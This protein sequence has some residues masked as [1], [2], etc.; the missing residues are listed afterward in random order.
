[1]KEITNDPHHGVVYVDGS[2]INNPSMVW[3]SGYHGYV[4]SDATIGKKSGDRPNKFIITSKG[5][6]DSA[7]AIK[8]VHDTVI[9]EYYINGYYSSG[10]VQGSNNTGEIQAIINMVKFGVERKLT[11]MSILSDSTYALGWLDKINHKNYSFEQENRANSTYITELKE[12]VITATNIGLTIKGYKVEAHSADMGNYIADQLALLGRLISGRIGKTINN[13]QVVENVRYWKSSIVK[14]ALI[15]YRSLYF[16]N[17]DNKE[18]RGKYA[19]LNYKKDV[20]PGRKSHEANFGYVELNEPIV[21][22]EEVKHIYQRYLKSLSLLSAVDTDMLFNQNTDML[23]RLF[24]TD[25]FTF[26]TRGRKHLSVL[27]E[28]IVCSEIYPPG[29]AKGALDKVIMMERYINE[30]R[31]RT[32]SATRY[33]DITDKVYGIDDKGRTIT[34]LDTLVKTIDIEYLTKDNRRVEIVLELGNDTISRNQ[35]KKLDKLEPVVTLVTNELSN[36]F[37]EYYVIVETKKNNDIGIYC[38]YFSNGKYH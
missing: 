33:T 29:L 11:T 7:N 18:T 25:I 30:Y 28:D 20:E 23:Y 38:N 22:I 3:G 9:P 26:N 10:G 21:L 32:R 17:G 36:N 24:G 2:C 13:I 12:A 6:L 8:Q 14:N 19:V 34:K 16:L 15:N 31:N 35:F 1:M 37:I 4:Y 5:Y 27:E